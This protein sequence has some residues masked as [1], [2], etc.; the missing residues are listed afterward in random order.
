MLTQLLKIRENLKRN[1][2][3]KERRVKEK[4]KERRVKQQQ[5][6]EVPKTTKLSIQVANN[7]N[8]REEFDQTV[9]GYS[10]EAVINKNRGYDVEEYNDDYES[11]GSSKRT[12]IEEGPTIRVE[13]AEKSYVNP[14]N[15][16]VQLQSVLTS[17]SRSEKWRGADE[18]DEAER[19]FH[20]NEL[21]KVMDEFYS[22][23]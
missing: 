5:L 15:T 18:S 11:L 4:V 14:T 23:E 22:L 7:K 21:D 3:K 17:N 13:L 10:D 12:S 16:Y 9:V 2:P 1:Q 6:E 8:D 19:L 20:E